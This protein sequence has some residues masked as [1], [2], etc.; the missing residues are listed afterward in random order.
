MNANDTILIILACLI[1]FAVACFIRI[2]SYFKYKRIREFNKDGL[3]KKGDM[4]LPREQG[5]F[6]RHFK[7]NK[8]KKIVQVYRASYKDEKQVVFIKID[9][10]YNVAI[11]SSVL[12][13][14]L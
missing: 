13:L 11:Y 12:K 5:D 1:V 14:A 6:L 2:D 7:N 8:P 10:G 9:N 4:V 3:F